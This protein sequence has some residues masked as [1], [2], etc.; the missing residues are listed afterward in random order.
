MASAFEQKEEPEPVQMRSSTQIM[1]MRKEKTQE[2]I[3]NEQMISDMLIS[4]SE[5]LSVPKATIKEV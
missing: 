1:G 2:Q 5:M 3:R 4:K